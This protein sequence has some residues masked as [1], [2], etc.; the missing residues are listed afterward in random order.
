MASTVM[1]VAASTSMRTVLRSWPFACA[2][3]LGISSNAASSGATL[4][5]SASPQG[6]SRDVATD[7]LEQLRIQLALKAADGLRQRRLRNAKALGRVR[8]MLGLRHLVKITQLQQLH[9]NLRFR[10][11]VTITRRLWKTLNL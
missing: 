9:A 10:L 8:H 4:S 11:N 7:A 2:M 6:V 1:V 5:S 3:A